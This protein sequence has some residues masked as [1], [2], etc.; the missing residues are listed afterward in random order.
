MSVHR[1]RKAGGLRVILDYALRDGVMND[2]GQSEGT[3]M[4]PK[5][6]L[7]DFIETKLAYTR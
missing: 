3:M 7:W 6:V 5:Y 4:R 2:F 1:K